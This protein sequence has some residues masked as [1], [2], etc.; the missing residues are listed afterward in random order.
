MGYLRR[1]GV[2]WRGDDAVFIVKEAD[3]G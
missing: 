2:G 3:R 1:V